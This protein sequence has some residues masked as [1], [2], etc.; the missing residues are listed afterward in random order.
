MPFFPSRYSR[1]HRRNVGFTLIELLVVIAIIGILASI[2]FPVFARAR[3]NA[4]RSSCASNLKQI[5]LAMKQ[6]SQ[7]YDEFFMWHTYRYTI[8]LGV[9]SQGWASVLTPYLKSEQIYQCPSQPNRDTR[10][11]AGNWT[12]PNENSWGMSDY[13]YNS[14]LGAGPGT[15]ACDNG[16]YLV[17]EAQVEFASNV[18]LLGDGGRGGE[19][20]FANYPPLASY[21]SG[22]A[23][24]QVTDLTCR[25]RLR[26][27]PGFFT[28]STD[29][30][31]AN[32][33]P[34]GKYLQKV[35]ETHLEGMN[36]AFVDGHVKW[37]KSEKLTFDDPSGTNVTFKV[38]AINAGLSAALPGCND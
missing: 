24:S 17:K 15:G 21:P 16:K 28:R 34:D 22:V 9:N 33:F 14:N 30:I 7:D 6:Y 25:P 26:Y 10:N 23:V 29:S 37:Y 1:V 5:S 12:S 11:A 27:Y 35:N 32:A 3:E 20:N 31:S 38:N 18:I 36:I 8:A 2:L 4:R 19:H 13:F